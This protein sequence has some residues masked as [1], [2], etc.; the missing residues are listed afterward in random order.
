M[1]II[2]KLKKRF[3]K[4]VAVEVPFMY[5]NLLHG[6]C[7]LITGGT[8]GIGF[9]IAESFVT[10]GATVIITGTNDDSLNT[11][12]KELEKKTNKKIYGLKFNNKNISEFPTLFSTFIKE[13]NQKVDILVNNAGLMNGCDFF[14]VSVQSF[15]DVLN[16]N[17]KGTFFI[18]QYISRYMIENKIH[19]NILNVSSSSIRPADGPYGISKWGINGFT[20]GLAERLLPHGIIVNGIAP[21]PTKTAMISNIMNDNILFEQ[22]PLGRYILPCEIANLSTILVS[23]LGKVIIGDVVYATG[24]AALI[25]SDKKYEGEF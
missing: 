12:C 23:A 11:A 17:L 22:K 25:T 9:A 3:I 24:G 15:E 19:G 5:G 10:N 8:K 16:V 21:G 1:K 14:D 13:I 2:K 20:L 4:K 18:S 7:A 6:R